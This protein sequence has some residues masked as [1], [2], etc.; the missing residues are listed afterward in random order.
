M[1]AT[2]WREALASWAI[3]DDLLAA[4]PENPWRLAVGT[5]AERADEARTRSTPS[6]VA[7]RAA[8]PPGGV[9][10]D[11]GAGAG[12]ASLPHA[13]VVSRIVG[14]D[15]NPAMLA[16]L[17][18]R[19]V[20]AGVDVLTVAGTW[21]EVAGRVP[22][23]D[24]VVCHH[25][26]YNVWELVPFVEALTGHAQSRVVV[27]IPD[28]HPLA[29]TGPYWQAV[30]GID[31]PSRPTGDDAITLLRG[32]GLDVEVERWTAP[33]TGATTAPEDLVALLR[34]HLCLTSDR[35]PELRRLL[36]EQPPP[37]ERNLL[38]LVWDGSP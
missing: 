31:R 22:V 2:D 3:P 11:V 24:V 16:A 34:R 27:E 21:P 5:F 12:A 35:D 29:W 36:E 37:T 25:V 10:L 14:V 23:A 4:A 13:D 19:A 33:H 20:A 28:Q 8:L 32:L 9:I 1:D 6:I 18:E 15:S 7:A 30:H 17:R 38:T 26:L